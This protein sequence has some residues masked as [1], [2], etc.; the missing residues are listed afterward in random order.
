MPK[1]KTSGETRHQAG[2]KLGVDGQASRAGRQGRK[3]GASGRER[4]ERKRRTRT[5]T[6]ING[7]EKNQ[8]RRGRLRIVYV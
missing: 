7:R 2:N 4:S 8:S 3:A 1:N 6:W 5:K